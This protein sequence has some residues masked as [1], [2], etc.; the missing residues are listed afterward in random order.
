MI[1]EKETDTVVING[2]D[3]TI[4]ALNQAGENSKSRVEVSE[5]TKKKIK[6]KL[7]ISFIIVVHICV[8]LL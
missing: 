5:K 6:T 7:T 3:L 8:V 2:H 1:V 4:E